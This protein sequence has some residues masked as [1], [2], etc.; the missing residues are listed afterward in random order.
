MIK[1]R[2]GDLTKDQDWKQKMADEWNQAEPQ[3]YETRSQ[4]P[5]QAPS[6]AS[7]LQKTTSDHYCVEST[8]SGVSKA[9]F[10]SRV[11]EAKRKEA[12][13]RPEWQ[14]TTSE[15]KKVSAEDRMASKIAA[16]VLKDNAKLRGVHSKDSIKMILER[17]ALKQ[18]KLANAEYKGPV[19]S[20]IEDRDLTKKANDPSNLPYL[21]K[22]P[23]V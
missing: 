3:A 14:S 17:E 7:K 21:H 18:M 2:V 10:T 5:S 8:V 9:S 13:E 11:K 19:V 15:R 12:E 4:A 6:Q 20:R 16:E 22:N 1:E 23:A